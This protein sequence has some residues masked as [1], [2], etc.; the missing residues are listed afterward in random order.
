MFQKLHHKK[1]RQEQ[2]RFLVEG[3]RLCR[4]ALQSGWKVDAAFISESFSKTPAFS[5]LIPE[6][7]YKQIIPQILSDNNLKRLADTEHPQGIV[8][9]LQ[10]PSPPDRLPEIFFRERLLLAV[11]SVRD[12]GNLGTLLRTADWFGISCIMASRDTADFFNSKVLRASMGGFLRLH[13]FTS[14]DLI[15]DLQKFKKR[16]FSILGST[17]QNGE[18]LNAFP[19]HPPAVLL[20]GGEAEGLTPDV[21]ALLDTRLTIPGGKAAESLNVSIAGSILLYHLTQVRVL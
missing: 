11:Q 5:Q 14:D 16:G 13:L 19:F 1:N 18:P 6:F 3:L 20:L 17:V 21:Q 10:I 4:E 8:L 7:R 2:G 9:A 15:T 12:P